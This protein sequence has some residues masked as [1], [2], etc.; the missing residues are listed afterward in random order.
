MA[1]KGARCHDMKT[2]EDTLKAMV[3]WQRGF[4]NPGSMRICTKH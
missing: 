4:F 1:V 3:E 2:M